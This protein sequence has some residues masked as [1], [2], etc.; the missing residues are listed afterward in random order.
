MI[1]YENTKG[2]FIDDIRNG[3]IADKIK[4]SFYLNNISNNNEAEYRAWSNSLMFMRNVLD[5]DE[6]SNDCS[7]AIEYQIPLTSKRV[8]FLIAGK[9]EHNN[10]N[11]VVIELKQW[12]NCTPTQIPDIV[13]A[14]TGGAER[15]VCHPSYQAYSYAKIIENFNEDI[16]KD[17]ISLIPC[18]Y[19]HNYKE[20]NR[21]NIEHE[22]YKEAL[23]LS[24]C[25]LSHDV[26]KLRKFIKTYIKEKDGINLLMKI[27]N[28][29]LKPAKAL[30][31]SL[32]S[33][34]TGNREFYLIDE[35]KIA[36]ETV[37]KLVEKS[38]RSTNTINGLNQKYKIIIQGGPGTGKSVVAIQLLCD[39]IQ[40]GYSVNYVTKNAAPRHVYFSKL[41]Q[42]DYKKKYIESLFRGSGAYINTP[43]NFFD[44]LIADE[45]HRLNEKSGL[46]NNLGENQIKEIIHASKVSVFLIDENQKVT[47]KDIGSVKLIEQFAKEEG[48]IIYKGEELNLV[49][50][51]RCNGSNSYLTFLDHLLEIKIT[52]DTNFDV[53]YEIRL[54]NNPNTMREQ[55]RIKNNINN[56][57]RMLAGYCYEWV[58]K[59]NKYSDIYDIELEKNFKAKWNFD[60]TNTWAID[61]ESFEQV[62]CIH[63]SQGLEF[64]Y[65]GVIIG[66]DLRY[67][68]SHIKTDYTQRAKSD[69]S[70]K[71]IKTTKNY[72]LADEIIKNTY[73]TLLSRG[74][75]GCY[76]YCE[77]KDL[78]KH[79]SNLLN[80]KIED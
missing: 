30:Q 70:L 17:D 18:A 80:K 55:L 50:Q 56:K 27:E 3:D 63:T 33:M 4:E 72:S 74:Q 20:Q 46:F 6:I 15:A 78:L 5:D 7:L 40:K 57:A 24:P 28:G 62:G 26:P 23:K 36:Y 35:Q 71:G 48:S 66:Q 79:I 34:L 19:L 49:S 2:G 10:N 65:V 16:Y 77:D 67:E 1:I 31:D 60:N 59:N 52:N 73:R 11:I 51:F 54:F 8:D 39:L 61:E 9:D 29:K 43:I 76:I 45:A 44:C 42:N 68:N 38:L 12:E 14:F 75:K 47:T 58:T 37:K 69:A 41:M 32:A 13:Y 25:F 53:D 64:D 22:V 21:H